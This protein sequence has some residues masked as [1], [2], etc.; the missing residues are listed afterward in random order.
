MS[1]RTTASRQRTRRPGQGQLLGVAGLLVVGAFLP[2]LYTSLGQ[3]NGINGPGIWTLYAGLLALA[4]GII[5]MPRLAAVQGVICGLV[6]V[7]LPVWQ[8]VHVL[9]LVGTAGWYPGPGL[10]LTFG[11]GV[12]SLAAAR[13]LYTGLKE[14]SRP[15]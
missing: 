15:A 7:A 10:V 14:S 3:L 5:P 9:S 8:V 11:G 13:T 6:G 1:Q 12:L 2:W 4:G